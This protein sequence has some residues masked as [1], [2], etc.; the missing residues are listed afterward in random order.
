MFYGQGFTV[1]DVV[2]HELSH[3]VTEYIS[4]LIYT[5]QSGGLNE[6]FS[7]IMG[8]ALDLTNSSGHDTASVRW[9]IGEE[10]PRTGTVR[11]MMDPERFGSAGDPR[12]SGTAGAWVCSTDVHYSSAVQNK[13]FALMVDGGTYNGYAINPIGLDKAVQVIYRAHDL[14][15][16]NSA[17]FVDAYNAINR[18][19]SELYGASGDTCVNVQKALL[20]TNMN[21]A[22]CGGASVPEPVPMVNADFEAGVNK[23]WAE[24]DSTGYITVHQGAGENGSW[25][26]W[27]GGFH[28]E[29]NEIWQQFSVPTN[30]STLLYSYKIASEDWPRFDYAYLLVNDTVLRTYMLCSECNTNGFVQGSVNL[31]AYAGQLITLKFRFKSDNSLT[32]NFFVDN[33]RFAPAGFVE[34]VDPNTVTDDTQADAKP[35]TLPGAAVTNKDDQSAPESPVEMLRT[36]FLPLVSQ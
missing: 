11:D 26:A 12:M 15:L 25:G 23:G 32:S 36:I 19:C 5:G 27:M 1:D 33:L 10:I 34:L 22:I 18:S 16:P 2:G 13:A 14:Y 7:D 21:G 9:D 24:Y 30:G 29:T 28:S 4:G 6:S 35:G 17:Q 31:S 8:E 20:A 3:A